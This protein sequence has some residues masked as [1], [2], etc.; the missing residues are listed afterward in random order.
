MLRVPTAF[1]SKSSNG[2]PAARSWLGWAA[3]WT[4]RS[5]RTRSM[6]ASTPLRSRI[7]SSMCSKAGYVA[8]RRAWFQRV[9]PS[10]PKNRARSLLSMPNTVQRSFA[11]N[12]TTSLPMRPDD[13]VTRRREGMVGLRLSGGAEDGVSPAEP[14]ISVHQVVQPEHPIA[15]PVQD[16]GD[17]AEVRLSFVERRERH[18]EINDADRLS[19]KEARRPFQ[20]HALATLDV[21]FQEIEVAY[22]FSQAELVEGADAH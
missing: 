22:S 3:A 10:G 20:R 19:R 12:E 16:T 21:H 9:S 7:S 4:T 2:R 1:T 18:F 5:G 11:K 13:P 6:H 17:V 15:V 8:A 14:A